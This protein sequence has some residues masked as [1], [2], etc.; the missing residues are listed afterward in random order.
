MAMIFRCGMPAASHAVMPATVGS[1]RGNSRTG[2]RAANA[3]SS[4]A[5]VANR[6]LPG[7]SVRY[8]AASSALGSTTL[9]AGKA[10]A[11]RSRRRYS[12]PAAAAAAQ[13]L[14]VASVAYGWV[15]SIQSA[16]F[17]SRVVISALSSRPVCTVTPGALP[18][19]SAPSLVATQTVTSAP[20]AAS[21]RES[22]RPS[23]VPLK[24]TIFIRRGTPSASPYC[25]AP[26]GSRCF[27]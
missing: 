14:R 15:A 3:G 2:S 22:A 11:G 19:S 8:C 27:R 21:R 26:C 9:P 25:R 12:T 18:C 4:F 24:T 5:P 10:L 1:T 13:I 7:F 16:A 6:T 23:V 17:C 20:S